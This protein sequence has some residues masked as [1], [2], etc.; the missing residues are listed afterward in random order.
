MVA[1][2]E[3]I[4]IIGYGK[5]GGRTVD[6]LADSGNEHLYITVVDSRTPDHVPDGIDY[7]QAEG[8]GWFVDNF[9]RTS[10]VDRIIPALPVHLAAEWLRKR[11]AAEDRTVEQLPVP[12][13]I[14]PLLPNP[15]KISADTYAIS[16]AT[17]LCP[18][19]CDEP[20]EFCTVTGLPRPTPLYELVSSIS[21]DKVVILSLQSRQFA[22]GAGGFYAADLWLL[23][24]TVQRH[25]PADFL[26]CTS[27]KCHGIITGLCI[28]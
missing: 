26:I 11:L 20:E 17:F 14:L 4:W 25:A 15:Y 21:L 23:L 24:E 27:C 28:R 3:S 22:S 6:L 1:A 18:A 19:D 10:K 7:V 16:H 12:E 9:H 5:F 8:I 2:P 13:K